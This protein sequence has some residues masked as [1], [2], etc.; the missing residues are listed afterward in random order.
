MFFRWDKDKMDI[1]GLV[2][3]SGGSSITLPL[4]SSLPPSRTSWWGVAQPTP[5]PKHTDR[6]LPGHRA[7]FLVNTSD[8]CDFLFPLMWIPTGIGYQ[9]CVSYLEDPAVSIV[10][11]FQS[12]QDKREKSLSTNSKHTV[13]LCSAPHQILVS[14]GTGGSNCSIQHVSTWDH[15]GVCLISA[16]AKSMESF[17]MSQC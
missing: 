16:K 10:I 5:K 11:S 4:P 13:L 1:F 6:A 9:T 2:F 8:H 3:Q 17:K 15:L 12:L 7:P 14:K